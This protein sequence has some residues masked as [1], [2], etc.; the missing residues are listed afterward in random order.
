MAMTNKYNFN[1]LNVSIKKGGKL[2]SSNFEN[3]QSVDQLKYLIQKGVGEHE[4][5]SLSVD[6]DG[7]AFSMDVISENGLSC[8]T[9]YDNVSQKSYNYFNS[10]Y[11]TSEKFIDI[12]GYECPQKI[13]CNDDGILIE[14]IIFFLENGKMYGR[15]EWCDENGSVISK[16]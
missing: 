10:N 15:V 1:N 4:I 13:I 14:I 2:I 5:E 12:A 8:I 3:V 6:Y 7:D 16:E 9:F 11:I